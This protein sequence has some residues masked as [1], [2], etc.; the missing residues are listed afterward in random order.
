ME[1]VR[2]CGDAVLWHFLILSWGI[3]ILKNQAVCDISKFSGNFNAACGFLMLFYAVF[4]RNSVRFCSI[5][6]SLTPPPRHGIS[7]VKA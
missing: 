3:A 6:T 2:V 4:T 5:P 1:G 7:L